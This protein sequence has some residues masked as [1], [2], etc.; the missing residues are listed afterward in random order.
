MICLTTSELETRFKLLGLDNV[1]DSEELTQ[2]ATTPVVD[3][4][5][6]L[7]GFPTPR[8]NEGINV[9]NLRRLLGVN[10]AK[11]PS[12][13][14]HPWYLEQE[15]AVVNCSPGWHFLQMD[16]APESI[17]QPI[18]YIRSLSAGGWMLPTA[19]E[20][21]LMLFLHYIGTGEQLLL[22]KH[23]WCVDQASMDRFVTV[24]AFGRN[25]LFVSGHP[26]DFASRGLGICA[27]LKLPVSR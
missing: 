4:G 27:K 2:Y 10:P 3:A 9:L 12:F 21:T 18:H 6:N 5:T 7:F 25:G 22:K 19:I 26:A 8:Q 14:D 1:F 24:G 16:V 11:Q 17:S 13:F 20:V 15:F 23:S